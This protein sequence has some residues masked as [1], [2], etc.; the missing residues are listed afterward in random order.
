MIFSRTSRDRDR[1]WRP[2]LGVVLVLVTAAMPS[3]CNRPERAAEKR[4]G[5]SEGEP[6]AVTAWGGTYEIFPEIGPLVAGRSAESHTHVTALADFSPLTRG[7][8]SIVLKS[9]DGTE[10]V[11]SSNQA[12]RPGIF[13]IEIKPRASGEFDLLFRV[14]ASAGR[15]EIAGGRVRVGD[16]VNPGGLLAPPSSTALAEK[17][18]AA[19]G[20]EDIAFLKEQQWKTPFSTA[21]AST[22]ELAATRVAP[23]RIVARPGGDRKITAPADGVLLAAPFPHPGLA[24]PAGAPL[25][26]MTPRLDPERSLAA[27]EGE[28]A[29]TEAELEL[30]TAEAKRARGLAEGGI[31]AASEHDRAEAAVAVATARAEAAR[32]DV[33]TARRARGGSGEAAEAMRIGAPFAGAVVEVE[34]SPGQAV[35][36]G[37]E[38]GRF[39]ASGPPWIEAWAAPEGAAGLTTGPTRVSL[40]TGA[41]E[42]PP[43]WSS[44][45]ARLVAIAPALDAVT[46]RRTL[47]LELESTPP[48]LAVGQ[49][50]EVELEAGSP[51]GG[52][53]I[54]A[55]AV[56]D[57]A[58]VAVVY[59]QVSGETMRRREVRVVARAGD[60]RLVEGLAA[61]ERI[62]AVGGGAVRRSSLVSSGV[63]EGHVH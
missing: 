40:R 29:S 13:P 14:D 12:K 39:V 44:L 4:S 31:L 7:N 28:L 49:S 35:E 3:A 30:A 23:A 63:G 54:P 19:A 20:G 60:L 46:G 10:E 8:V 58:G 16:S 15:E 21:W 36:A 56:I 22:G 55:T 50:I 24:L 6:W 18:A 42:S 34:V 26:A 2:G 11:F 45:P 43:G 41:G 17:A 61:G 37:D 48:G 1:S 62:V 33:A 32:R 51:R 38:L 5:A 9:Q 59:V 52:I 53:V 47:M 27:L 25:F 57:D